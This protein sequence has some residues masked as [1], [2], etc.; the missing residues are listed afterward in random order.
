MAESAMWISSVTIAAPNPRELAGF[1]EELL[2]WTITALEGP[3]LGE[4]PERYAAVSTDPLWSRGH[5]PTGTGLHTV[6][7]WSSLVSFGQ[8]GVVLFK[9]TYPTLTHVDR[10]RETARE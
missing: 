2:G 9:P 8:A 3:A 10:C 6:R 5:C 1:Y 4:P 7:S